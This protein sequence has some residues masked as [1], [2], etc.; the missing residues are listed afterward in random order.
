[1]ATEND[2]NPAL[3]EEKI[4]SDTVAIMP[5]HLFGQPCEMEPIVAL[6]QKYN[7]KIIDTLRTKTEM[8]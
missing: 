3:I 1:M 7:F 8:D 5:V 6:A 2:V 4:D